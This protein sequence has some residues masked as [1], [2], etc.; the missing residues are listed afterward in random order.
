MYTILKK[1]YINDAIRGS[2]SMQSTRFNKRPAP[3][4]TLLSAIA[5]V[6]ALE[7]ASVI[8]ALAGPMPVLAEVKPAPTKWSHVLD[9][10]EYTAEPGKLRECARKLPYQF[11]EIPDTLRETPAY[12]IYCEGIFEIIKN[13]VDVK[14]TE[15]FVDIERVSDSKITTTV[16]DN[17]PGFSKKMLEKARLRAHLEACQESLDPKEFETFL[18]SKLDAL[19]KARLKA[20]LEAG[21][22]ENLDPK[23][24]ETFLRSKLEDFIPEYNEYRYVEDMLK[25]DTLREELK[26]YLGRNGCAL[27]EGPVIDSQFISYRHV[28]G[29]VS[30]IDSDKAKAK[31]EAK[32]AVEAGEAKESLEVT[33]GCGIGLAQLSRCMAANDNG[34]LLIRN[35]E[36]GG[37]I[38]ELSSSLLKTKVRYDEIQSDTG[39]YRSEVDMAEFKF[40][41]RSKK[42]LG[43]DGSPLSAPGTPATPYTPH[44]PLSSR[45][46]VMQETIPEDGSPAPARV[47]VRRGSLSG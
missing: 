8:I 39:T 5:E 26:L 14:A 19:E 17:G 3:V 38:I 37:A 9:V 41:R 27:P 43:D 23:E 44:T 21:K 10:P 28:L 47:V 1:K 42:K 29:Q 11:P 4:N 46:F 45:F 30:Q 2:L 18:R 40:I 16:R 35:A 34:N 12:E 6:K 33:G 20:R 13:A 32:V 15:V 24:F 25:D 22:E 7:T 31:L 36:T